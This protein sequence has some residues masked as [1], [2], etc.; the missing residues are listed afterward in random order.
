M[1]WEKLP[2]SVVL[3]LG[4][5]GAGLAC[6]GLLLRDAPRRAPL[7]VSEVGLLIRSRKP[8]SSSN[9]AVKSEPTK[10]AAASA[11]HPESK[12]HG[13]PFRDR[14]PVGNREES[15]SRYRKGAEAG[16]ALAQFS[17]AGMLYL[18][19]RGVPDFGQAASWYRRAAE[20]GNVRAQA[21]LGTM[22]YQG[23]GV[24][25]NFP[26]AAFWY[27]KAAGQ[28]YADAQYILGVMSCQGNGVVQD[29]GQALSWFRKAAEQ[30]YADAEYYLGWMYRDGRGVAQDDG[31]AAFWF[32]KAAEQEHA[33]AYCALGLLYF[34]GRG[35][36]RNYEKAM[37]CL[38][39]SAELGDADAQYIL[40][41]MRASESR[42]EA[43]GAPHGAQGPR[44][45]PVSPT[46]AS[47]EEI[48]AMIQAAERR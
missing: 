4:L 35:V 11:V 37:S 17:L 2:G 18:G 46:S 43:G 38:R 20:Q 7:V 33:P 40:G 30:R 12:N 10:R 21:N 32:L 14:K 9:R 22:Y 41:E 16:D 26:A 36:A 29:Y 24:E 13:T 47:D 8:P 27:R 31:L 48:R 15:L 23:R 42:G 1:I 25:K 19:V 44:R 45:M 3:S 34:S 5:H 39:K 28:G 6:F